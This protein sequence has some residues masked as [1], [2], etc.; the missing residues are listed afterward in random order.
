MA[1]LGMIRFD[2]GK[3]LEFVGTRVSEIKVKSQMDDWSWIPGELNPADMRTRPRVEQ[4]EMEIGSVYQRGYEWM[5]KPESEWPCKKEYIAP[6]AEE[7]RKDMVG[8][9]LSEAKVAACLADEGE[10]P[11]DGRISSLRRLWR[12]YA[13]VF[14]AAHKCR[15]KPR[16][17][18]SHTVKRGQMKNSLM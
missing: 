13:F 16:I 4:R 10:G 3:F 6:P 7:L 8:I 11:F 1:V 9:S 14:V 5:S 15:K 17:A 18:N 12:I 2:S